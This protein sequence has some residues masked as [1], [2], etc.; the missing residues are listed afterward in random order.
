MP[1]QVPRLILAFM[2]LIAGFLGFRSMVVPDSFGETGFYRADFVK[3]IQESPFRHAGRETCANCHDLAATT[4]HTQRGVGCESCHGA[5]FSH[6]E[7]FEKFKPE[8]AGKDVACG[9][10]HA[11]ATGRPKGFPQVDPKEHSGGEACRTCHT[12]HEKVSE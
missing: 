8:H 4:L 1:P 5:S 10:C 6:T 12:I 7:D 11:L 9:R 2:V 3:E